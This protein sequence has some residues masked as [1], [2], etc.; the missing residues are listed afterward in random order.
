[1]S[2]R[3]IEGGCLSVVSQ[4]DQVL[5]DLL[6]IKTRV[7]E[8]AGRV[9]RDNAELLRRVSIQVTSGDETVFLDSKR[10]VTFYAPETN[11]VSDDKGSVTCT[12]TQEY[13][14]YK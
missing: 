9:L 4:R 10:L 5:L 2:H 7:G 13:R 14:I 6:G 8:G 3:F 11:M 12:W 1:M